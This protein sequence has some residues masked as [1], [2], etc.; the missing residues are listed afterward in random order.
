MSIPTFQVTDGKLTGAVAGPNGEMAIS[1]G[2]IDG[3][4]ISFTVESGQFKAV[5]TGMVSGDDLK[6]SGQAGDHPFELA[7]KHVKD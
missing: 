3:D 5:V 6:L 2:K 4:K 7:A 1:E